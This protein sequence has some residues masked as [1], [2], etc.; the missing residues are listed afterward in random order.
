MIKNYPDTGIST[1]KNAAG[2]TLIELMIVV[3]IV[4]LLAAIGYPSYTAYV[5]R[6]K[7]SEGRALLAEVA[8]RLERMYSDCNAYPATLATAGANSCAGTDTVVIPSTTSENGYYTIANPVSTDATRQ[9]YTLTV[10]PAGAW[11]DSDC[12]N[13]SLTSAGTRGASNAADATEIERCW[14]K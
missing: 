12:G 3:A 7:R 10:T 14:G 6:G 5:E 1:L 13:L 4:A 2:F 11:T 9:D 8:N